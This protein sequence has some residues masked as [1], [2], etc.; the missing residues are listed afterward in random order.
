[1]RVGN[2]AAG[3]YQLDV[4]G[5][6]LGA[7]HEA[8]RT[9]LE[10]AGPAWDL[11]LTLM[12]FIESGWKA[13]R[14]R[15]LGGARAAAAFHALEGHGVGGRRPR[16]FTTSRITASRG[17]SKKWRSLRQKI[18]D[19]VC[20]KGF[21]AERNT[22]TQYYG[23][24]ELDASVLMIPIVGFLPPK[25][26]PRRRDGGG[27]PPASHDGRLRQP[28]RLGEVRARRRAVGPRGCV[29]GV[30]V[31]DGRR[32]AP[33]RQAR[34]GRRALRAAVVVAQRPRPPGRGVRPDRQSVSWAISPRPSP[35]SRSSTRQSVFS[36]ATTASA[37]RTGSPASSRRSSG[38]GHEV[39]GASQA[40]VDGRM[41]AVLRA[42]RRRAA[43]ADRRRTSLKAVTVTPGT[44]G[45]AALEEIAEPAAADG[46][47]LV[48]TIAVGI[49]GT[50]LEI[51]QGEYGWAP[52]GHKRL[53]LG[54][55]SIGKVVL[56]P[57]RL[58]ASTRETSS[59]GSCAGPT[60]SPAT[61]AHAASGTSVATAATS[62]TASRSSTASCASATGPSPTISSRSTASSGRSVCCSSRRASSPRRGSRP[63]GWATAPIGSR[64]RPSSPV[65]ARSAL[66]AALLGVQRGLEVHVIDQVTDGIKPDLVRGPR[67][68]VPPRIDPRRLQGS[69]R[70]C[71]SAPGSASLVFDAI[72]HVGPG[73]VVCLTGVSRR[74]VATS[75]STPAS[76]TATMV[77]GN[78]GVVGSVN[79]NRRHYEQA[80]AA[81]SK[82]DQG[83][84]AQ[85]DHP[86]SAARPVRRSSGAAARRR[87]GG[88]R[89]RDDVPA[90]SGRGPRAGPTG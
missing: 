88:A 50:D 19:E 68:P 26:S 35:T 57:G 4:Y 16:R 61:A 40:P 7:L 23:S 3:Q 82:A 31:L 34:R 69:R 74:S 8:R 36:G 58:R 39:E 84:L 85:A 13:S 29:L 28:V 41:R 67:R 38:S 45:S 90:A 46:P 83:W 1:M 25:D 33:H 55:E 10:P 66:L 5:E 72:E 6:V 77:L 70:R 64:G 44:G 71:S 21:D 75:R 15:D 24:Q 32:P 53:V 86:A 79:A 48:E 2:A 27:D 54:H 65:P 62:S 47:V 89:R 30:L 76:R 20:E 60:R 52:P 51:S 63:S 12:D 17:P 59:S 56:G 14:R 81:L 9:G 49:C 43:G 11:E 37:T 42:H 78:E 87:E 73:G 22:F 18:H 80:A